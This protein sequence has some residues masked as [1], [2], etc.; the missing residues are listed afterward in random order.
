MTWEQKKAKLVKEI[1]DR[2]VANIN[3]EFENH[4]SEIREAVMKAI[5]AECVQFEKDVEGFFMGGGMS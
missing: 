1:K 5:K 2:I 3:K 4:P